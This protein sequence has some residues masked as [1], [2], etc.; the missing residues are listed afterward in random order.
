MDVV[1]MRFSNRV[2]FGPGSAAKLE[3]ES[4]ALGAKHALVVTD[5]GIRE[6]GL[7]DHALEPLRAAGAEV[8]VYDDVPPEPPIEALEKCFDAYR[9]QKFDL[10]VGI[11]GG[12]PLD[13]AKSMSVLLTNEGEVR[14][15]LGIDLVPKPGTPSIMI[16]TTAG[17]GAEA[18]PNAIFS[19]EEEKVKKA[20]V[21]SHVIADVAILDPALTVGLPPK[22]T[23]ASGVDALTHCLETY[24]SLNATPISEMFS[25][26]GMRLISRSIRSAVH[27]GRDLE[28]R[29]NMLLG[30]YYGGVCLAGASAGA[31]HALSYPLGG[32]C[33]VPHGFGNAMLFPHVMEFNFISDLNKFAV[34]AETLGEDVDGLSVREAA[35]VSVDAVRT[36]CEDVGVP[37]TL[38][39]LDLD[40]SVIP[41][42]AEAAAQI[43]RILDF[44]PRRMTKED[45]IGVYERAA[46]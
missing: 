34:I 46:G 10:V 11:G 24:V 14:D 31:I 33:H 3:E 4:R 18:T 17:T 23:A 16:P 32:R 19:I 27:N 22:Q 45:I 35:E 41:E 26:E 2:F 6:A 1:R 20:I 12:S 25:L 5:K 28:A 37:T 7:L 42:L 9:K 43:T 30:S 29:A 8:D 36:L 21:S 15:Y 38:R 39:E 13:V 44:N 40:A